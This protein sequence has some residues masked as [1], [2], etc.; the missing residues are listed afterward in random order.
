MRDVRPQRVDTLIRWPSSV[1]RKSGSCSNFFIVLGGNIYKKSG[2][3]VTSERVKLDFSRLRR[4]AQN[5]HQQNKR[6]SVIFEAFGHAR[7]EEDRK[8][9]NMRE[10]GRSESLTE[11]GA[12]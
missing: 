6:D 8:H 12:L 4:E 10:T 9:A 2:T 1:A 7:G 11:K 5:V 3:G